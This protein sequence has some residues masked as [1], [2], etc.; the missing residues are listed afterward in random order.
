MRAAGGQ[1]AAEKGTLDCTLLLCVH[2]MVINTGAHEPK[3]DTYAHVKTHTH[4]KTL[5]RMAVLPACIMLFSRELHTGRYLS[6][7]LYLT[8]QNSV[9]PFF[10]VRKCI[11]IYIYTLTIYMGV[12]VCVCVCFHYV[13][14]GF[15]LKSKLNKLKACGKS[16]WDI[17]GGWFLILQSHNCL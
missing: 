14:I 13:Y 12:C 17:E 3:A 10:R 16:T 7:I 8:F 2:R 5:W 4:L 9:I 15:F 11:Y 6:E 1:E